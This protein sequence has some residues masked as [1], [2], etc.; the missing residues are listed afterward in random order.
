MSAISK[1][2]PDTLQNWHETTSFLIKNQSFVISQLNDLTENVGLFSSNLSSLQA[3]VNAQRNYGHDEKLV[4]D[5]GAKLEAVATD[6]EG[7]KEHYNRYFE[8]QKSLR[9]ETEAIK[10][11]SFEIL[12]V[13]E[14]F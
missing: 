9:I 1:I 6:I 12:Y 3:A 13:T 11:S 14:Q 4:A 10:E 8:L 7:I 2:F 5:F